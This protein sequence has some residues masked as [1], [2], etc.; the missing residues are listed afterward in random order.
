MLFPVAV[1][2]D[3]SALALA[4]LEVEVL[5]GIALSASVAAAVAG[6]PVEEGGNSI[7]RGASS[8]FV[9]ANALT[10]SVVVD[11]VSRAVLRGVGALAGR[12]VPSVAGRAR[13]LKASAAADGEGVVE[14]VADGAGD[15]F[16]DALA[17][18]PE[19]TAFALAGLGDP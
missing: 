5:V 8:P 11:V 6:V 12:I 14:V 7:D 4:V 1:L 9:G 10:A 2:E 17:A 19:L 16:A 15:L 18:V 3:G 13:R